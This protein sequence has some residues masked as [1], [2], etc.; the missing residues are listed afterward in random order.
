MYRTFNSI[1]QFDGVYVNRRSNNAVRS[2][3]NLMVN[4]DLSDRHPVAV[5]AAQK[6]AYYIRDHTNRKILASHTLK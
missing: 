5:S 2:Y 1:V 6:V 3:I 4:H